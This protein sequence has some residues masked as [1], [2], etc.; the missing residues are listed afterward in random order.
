M[1]THFS[2]SQITNFLFVGLA[3]PIGFALWQSAQSIV[4]FS[5]TSR[6]A[7]VNANDFASTSNET[8]GVQILQKVRRKMI[9]TT[10]GA[11]SKDAVAAA[12]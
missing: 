10:A 1:K 9:S 3:I 11:G 12:K 7:S 2:A 6:S 5:N 4:T 8:P